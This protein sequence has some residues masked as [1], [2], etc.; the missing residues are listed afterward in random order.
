[1][2]R[3][4]QLWVRP[5]VDGAARLRVLRNLMEHTKSMAWRW[6]TITT[7]CGSV[8]R[9]RRSFT[10]RYRDCFALPQWRQR[11]GVAGLARFRGGRVGHQPDGPDA[12]RTLKTGLT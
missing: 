1:M 12:A 4:V 5:S 7:L 6:D 2:R 11:S 8:E 10:V 3:A 9:S